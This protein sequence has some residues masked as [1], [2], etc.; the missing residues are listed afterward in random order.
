MRIFLLIW[1][2]AYHTLLNN[3]GNVKTCISVLL[4]VEMI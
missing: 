1:Y 2:H 3:L 4:S